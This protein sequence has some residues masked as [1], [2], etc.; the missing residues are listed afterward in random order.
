MHMVCLHSRESEAVVKVK[1]SPVRLVVLPE[2]FWQFNPLVITFVVVVVIVFVFIR[3][4]VDPARFTDFCELLAGVL[5]Q[6]KP[7]LNGSL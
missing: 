5:M 1:Q 6:Q 7:G 2:I 3:I 4:K